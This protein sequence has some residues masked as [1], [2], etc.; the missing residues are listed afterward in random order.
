MWREVIEELQREDAIG[1]AFP[2]A[3]HRHQDTVEYVSEPGKLPRVA[4][5]GKLIKPLSTSP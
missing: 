5:D 2:I 3:C 1:D 4:P